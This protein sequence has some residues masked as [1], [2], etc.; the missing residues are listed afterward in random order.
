MEYPF[1]SWYAWCYSSSSWIVTVCPSSE[2][3]W[4]E[5]QIALDRVSEGTRL[6]GEIKQMKRGVNGS[7]VARFKSGRRV[8]Y[9]DWGRIKGE[10]KLEY[11]FSYWQKRR[12]RGR[13]ETQG[14]YDG[15]RESMHLGKSLANRVI[16]VVFFLFSCFLLCYLS[17]LI[18]S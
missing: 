12:S 18:P 4:H 7:R 17:C 11:F 2:T 16:Y 8:I 5:A 1:V 13:S 10:V 9:W 6:D 3:L 15:F 14:E